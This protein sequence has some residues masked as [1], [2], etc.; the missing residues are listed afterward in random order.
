L[1]LSCQYRESL[2]RLSPSVLL[3]S[4]SVL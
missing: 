4:S 1:L 3:L 2:C